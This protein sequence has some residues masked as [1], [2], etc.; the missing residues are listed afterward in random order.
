MSIGAD[1]SDVELSLD[2]VRPRGG[3]ALYDAIYRSVDQLVAG[4]AGMR[5][6]MVVVSDGRDA[7]RIGWK[8]ASVHS[9]EEALRHAHAQ[10]VIIYT[11]GLGKNLEFERSIVGDLTTRQVLASFARSTGGRLDLLEEADDLDAAYTKVIEELRH[12][13]SMAFTPS[14]EAPRKRRGQLYEGWRPIEIS[15]DVEG[16]R[17]RAR[18][19]YFVPSE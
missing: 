6:V 8:Q 19:G 10:N 15:V 9:L 1:A 3:T 7:E 13:Y 16:A 17:V 4:P 12:H 14:D 2:G 5:R 11:L 18:Q